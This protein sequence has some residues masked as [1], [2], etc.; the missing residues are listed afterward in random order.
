MLKVYR[1]VCEGMCNPTI[2]VA[3]QA[4]RRFQKVLAQDGP[5]V[6]AGIAVPDVGDAYR[7]ITYTDHVVETRPN[8]ARCVR[9]GTE[10]RFGSGPGSFGE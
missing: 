7:G 8:F 9:C 10:R 4:I 2:L 1:L 3:D 6:A 5:E